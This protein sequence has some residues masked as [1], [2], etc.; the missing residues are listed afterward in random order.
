VPGGST[1]RFSL[2]E[3]ARVTIAVQRRTTGRRVGGVCRT[4]SRRNRRYRLA[5]RARDAAGNR[6]AAGTASFTVVR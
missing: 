4:P 5:V 2:S 3:A 1:L 6:S